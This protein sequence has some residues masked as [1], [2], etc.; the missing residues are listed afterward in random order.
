M[1]LGSAAKGQL[2]LAEARVKAADARKLLSAGTD[3]LEAKTAK[4]RRSGLF[5][6][7]VAADEF[8]KSHRPKFRNEKHAAQWMTLNTYCQ[9]IRSLPISTIDTEAVMNVLQPIWT[10]I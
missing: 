4:S 7:L 2:S 8:M 3:P 5:P 9:P 6:A 10:K 1:G